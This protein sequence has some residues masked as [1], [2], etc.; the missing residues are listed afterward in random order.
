M[1]QE[2]IERDGAT[3]ISS[4][5]LL[6]TFIC[7]CGIEHQKQKTAICNTSG[8]FCKDCTDKNTA[9]KRIKRKIEE[10]NALL[11]SDI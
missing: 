8:A 10:M 1:L 3:Y 5:G 2:S 6:I 7:K 9:I 4:Q 11:N